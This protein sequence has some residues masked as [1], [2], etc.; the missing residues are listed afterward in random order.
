MDN[1]QVEIE[2]EIDRE[3]LKKIE[4]LAQLQGISPESYISRILTQTVVK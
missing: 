4:T 1:K 2:L 3:L